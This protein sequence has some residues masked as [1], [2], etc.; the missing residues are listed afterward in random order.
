MKAIA[1]IAVFFLGLFYLLG[2]F[3]LYK[4]PSGDVVFP[5]GF[6]GIIAAI[7][8]KKQKEKEPEED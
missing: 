3:G 1:Y 4:E 5:L 7:L 8:S 6:V 2:C